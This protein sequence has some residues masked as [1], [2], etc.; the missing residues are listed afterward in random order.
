[1]TRWYP[2]AS[3]DDEFLAEAP[4]RFVHVV[5]A[6]APAERVWQVLS[7]DDVLVSWSRLITG[8]EWTSPRPF[9]VGTTRTVT[10][11]HGV[12]ALQERFYRWETDQRMTF[13]ADAANRPLFR[14]FAEDLALEPLPHRTRLTWTFAMEPATGFAP[15]L[16]PASPLLRRITRGWAQGLARRMLRDS[17]PSTTGSTRRTEEDRR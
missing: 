13:S 1:M 7:S 10:L 11:V 5:D 2:L 14:R 8:V 3:C 6:P 12:A 17:R 15:L 16:H 9:G 4:F